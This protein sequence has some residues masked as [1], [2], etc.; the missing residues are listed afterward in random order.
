MGPPFHQAPEFA[1]NIPGG[2]PLP[3]QLGK[4]LR[5]VLLVPLS[6][7]DPEGRS[8]SLMIDRLPAGTPG[9]HPI[10]L[11]NPAGPG[12]QGLPTPGQLRGEL[13]AAVL[14]TYDIIGFD[15]RFIGRSTPITCGQPAEDLGGIWMRWPHPGSF[16]WDVAAA[17]DR[18]QAC[19]ANSGWALPYATT[20][21]TARDMDIIRGVLGAP[22]MS[23][24]GFSY[25]GYL[26]AVYTAL[27]PRRTGR[28]VLD[29]PVDPDHVW[30]GFGLERAAPV[31]GI[32]AHPCRYCGLTPHHAAR[33]GARALP[34]LRRRLRERRRQQLPGNRPAPARRPDVRLTPGP[35]GRR[36]PGPACRRDRV[37]GPAGAGG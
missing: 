4:S 1:N 19:A 2:M 30:Y 34:R 20:A 14:N 10:L 13:P 26:G 31:R 29:S 28:F 7:A 21:N 32:A 18:A 27:F 35:V 15:P 9:P 36:A 22:R 37:R 6:Y 12:G 8:I 17:R 5:Q 23:F 33:V 3:A 16:P 11:T 25:G 24:L